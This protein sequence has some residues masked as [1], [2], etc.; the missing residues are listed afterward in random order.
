V[1]YLSGKLTTVNLR[2][3]IINRTFR[4][5]GI[6][7][8]APSVTAGYAWV[9]TTAGDV[10]EFNLETGGAPQSHYLISDTAEAHAPIKIPHLLFADETFLAAHAEF[11]DCTLTEAAFGCQAMRATSG[12]LFTAHNDG[13]VRFWHGDRVATVPRLQNEP[14]VS[15]T[16]V[17]NVRVV[18]QQPPKESLNVREA[19]RD[20]IV[21]FCLASLQTDMVVTAGRDGLVKVWK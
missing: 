4:G 7:T 8:I 6:Q 12:G 3:N 5:T 11:E 17:G 9:S 20:A 21:D 1:A 18:A 2:K 10:C 15:V 16:N 19:H 13:V 14:T